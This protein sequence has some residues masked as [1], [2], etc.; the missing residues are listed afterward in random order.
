MVSNSIKMD[1][2]LSQK[3]NE[4]SETSKTPVSKIVINIIREYLKNNDNSN[5]EA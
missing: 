5:I 2:E 1:D 3:L 4:L